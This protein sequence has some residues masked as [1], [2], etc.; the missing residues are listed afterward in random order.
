MSTSH[1]NRF[2]NSLLGLGLGAI[3]TVLPLHAQVPTLLNYQGRVAVGTV[4]FEG[5]GQFKFALVNATGTVTYWKSNGSNIFP[6]E[7]LLAVSLPVNKGL[8][9]VLLGDTTIANMN[10]I[11]PSVFANPDVRLRVWFNNG[12][13]G[14]QLLTPDQRLA[15]TAYLADGAVSSGSLASGAVTSGKIA[16]GAIGGTHIAAGS[17]DFGRLAVPTA[18]GAGQVLG[19]NG[20]SLS[21]TTPT[22][23]GGLTLPFS[24][25]QS[26]TGALLTINNTATSG[27]AWGIYGRSAVSTGVFGQTSGNAT[28]G[29][30]GR[31]DGTT[32]VG[33]SGV[34]GYSSTKGFG[35]LAISE[36]GTALWA[37]TNAANQVAVY[38]QT[39]INT[40][41]AA[42]FNHFGNGTGVDGFS[43]GGSGV[44]GATRGNAVAGVFGRNDGATGIGG[45]G[46]FGYSS[47]KGFGVQAISEGGTAFWAAT[48][49]ANEVAVYGQTHVNS[50][51]AAAFNHYGTGVALSVFSGGPVALRVDGRASVR[52]LEI[53]G[54]ADLAEP[55]AM[56]E[57]DVAPGSVVV[58]DALNPGKLRRSHSAYDK[59]V[60]GIVSGADGINPGISMIQEDMLEA[61]ENVALSGR[62]YVKANN[63]AGDIEP[64]DLLTTSATPGEAMKASDHS[65]SQGAI[66]GKAMTRL[67]E[68]SGKVLVLVTLQ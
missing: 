45:S 48:N 8:Y 6:G 58:I 17:L 56:S 15:P 3:V 14:S 23:G 66:L 33:G 34:F 53:T 28:A 38:G 2:K 13:N 4:N 62:V 59:R 30:L 31:N 41:R 1:S 51:K 64:G 37:A 52:T 27:D 60:A 29:V 22:G 39:H 46:V 61:G 26:S 12:V 63:S 68:S 35:V 54:G 50:S 57:E 18:P 24:G 65:R 10:A 9:S 42:A 32:G 49:A 25:I 36:G 19:F 67:S 11:P 43:Q 44:V 5:N 55:F 20:S 16:A 47:T 21:W 40:S 7:P